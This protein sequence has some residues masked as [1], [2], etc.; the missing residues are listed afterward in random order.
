[1]NND[2]WTISKAIIHGSCRI[3]GKDCRVT[4]RHTQTRGTLEE[5]AAYRPIN[6]RTEC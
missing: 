2:I 3:I 5:E 1:M 6:G 4:T